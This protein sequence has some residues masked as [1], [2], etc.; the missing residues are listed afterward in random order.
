MTLLY[1]IAAGLA[2]LFCHYYNRWTQGRTHS[3]FKEYLFGEWLATVQ[4]LMANIMAVMGMYAALPEDIGGKLLIG[5]IYAAYMTGYAADSVLNKDPKPTTPAP[6]KD[7][8]EDAFNDVKSTLQTKSL[9][10]ILADDADL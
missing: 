1:M 3:T 7:E 8:H 9:K 10:D 5:A 2:G 4:S 6:A